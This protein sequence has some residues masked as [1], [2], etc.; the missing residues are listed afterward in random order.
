MGLRGA[1]TRVLVAARSGVLVAARSR[2][3]VSVCTRARRGAGS[4]ADG[5]PKD[6]GRVDLSRSRRSTGARR[7]FSARPR[8]GRPWQDG[9]G[10]GAPRDGRPRQ[11]GVGV[12]SLRVRDG[13]RGIERWA[14]V[15]SI[16]IAALFGA[17]GADGYRSTA[18]NVAAGERALRCVPTK[19]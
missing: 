3:L 13:A 9:V 18:S 11:D 14:I 8:G 12:E 5:A 17:T 16:A 6:V 15:D 7:G 1:D 4:H 10:T 19:V 2:V